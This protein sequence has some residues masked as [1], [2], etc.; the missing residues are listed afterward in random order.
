MVTWFGFLT[1]KIKMWITALLPAT[2]IF[3][4]GQLF[5]LPIPVPIKCVILLL[6]Y[7]FGYFL[8]PYV[9]NDKYFTV[10]PIATYFATKVL[11][12][13]GFLFIYLIFIFAHFN[14]ILTLTVLQFWVYVTWLGW[15]VPYVNIWVT[16][17]MLISSILLWYNFLKVWKGDPGIVSS[18]REE[19]LRVSYLIFYVVYF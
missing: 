12:L 10:L 4:I 13:T 14:I 3:V 11:V 17:A 9:C 15:I 18:T 19:K 16:I 7:V 1:Q 5:Q 6:G 8:R 2:A